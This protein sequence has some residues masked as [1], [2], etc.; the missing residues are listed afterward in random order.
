MLRYFVYSTLVADE[1][2]CVLFLSVKFKGDLFT[3]VKG[4]AIIIDHGPPIGKVH[5]K[6]VTPGIVL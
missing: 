5:G 6:K 2:R 3:S 1:G 4:D